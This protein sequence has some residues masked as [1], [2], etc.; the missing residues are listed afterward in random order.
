MIED[1]EHRLAEL[2]ASCRQQCSQQVGI[3]NL[4]SQAITT[5][6]SSARRDLAN[7]KLFATTQAK[8]ILNERIAGRY[9]EEQLFETLQIIVS[10][11][12]SYL[13]Q[14]EEQ[15]A[16]TITSKLKLVQHAHKPSETPDTPQINAQSQ[17]SSTNS[18]ASTEHALKDAQRRLKE[19]TSAE[20][21][22]SALQG[23]R[24]SDSTESCKIFD[25]R[26]AVELVIDMKQGSPDQI[27]NMRV[28]CILAAKTEKE[29]EERAIMEKLISSI[30]C[31][32]WIGTRS[33]TAAVN[34]MATRVG[35]LLDLTNEIRLLSRSFLFESIESVAGEGISITIRFSN[36]QTGVRFLVKLVVDERYPFAPNLPFELDARFARV[37]EGDIAEILAEE[38]DANGWKLLTRVCKR[39]DR[40]CD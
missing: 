2:E 23:W 20:S 4:F 30:S 32:E 14:L 38:T 39:L 34:G 3:Y 27:E 10:T 35:R 28:S 33:L 40:L 37:T 24:L 1:C 12:K 26:N 11:A 7:L 15:Q 25:F 5:H 9:F 21:L 36:A 18:I 22:C 31:S 17:A 13:N 16:A 6:Q 19:S 8:T 29:L